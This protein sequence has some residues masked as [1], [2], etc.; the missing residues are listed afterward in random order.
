MSK[1]RIP[2]AMA[3]LLAAAM[4]AGA[5]NLVIDYSFN[6]SAFFPV[7]G[8]ARASLEQAAADL[9]AVLTNGQLGS[10]P[11]DS[12]TGTSSPSSSTVNWDLRFT[13]PS[14]NTTVTLSSPHTSPAFGAD[15]I[16]IFVGWQ[17]LAGSTL[18]QGGPGSASIGLSGGVGSPSSWISAVGAMDTL[19]DATMNR[20]GGPLIGSINGTFTGGGT[21]A[22]YSLEYGSFIGNLWFD[23]DTD[24]NS[25]TDT[26]ATLDTAWNLDLGLPGPGQS[27]FY[28]VALHELMHAV[29]FG[30]SLSWDNLPADANHSGGHLT[31]GLTSPRLSDGVPQEAVMTPSIVIGTRKTL[32]QADLQYLGA[33]G[34]NVV[35]E[36]S[37]S[38]LMILVGG[39]LV[40][41]RRRA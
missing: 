28:S 17:N 20:G 41:R 9:S 27:D 10:L 6:T 15:N 19:S 36:P 39:S 40:L 2:F 18:G 35:P 4:P 32:T 5:V 22:P 34:F 30:T 11:T 25:I 7:G 31:A 12:F 24:N 14:D 38:L 26:Q 29:G 37:G 1:I 13:N 16:R 21:P 3:L 33:I 23:S 8:S